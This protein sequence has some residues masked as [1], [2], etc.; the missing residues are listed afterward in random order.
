MIHL[1][2]EI[3]GK[4]LLRNV[5]RF[6]SEHV[7]EF[8][9]LEFLNGAVLPK[10]TRKIGAVHEQYLVRIGMIRTKLIDPEIV[11]IT[12]KKIITESETDVH[13]NGIVQAYGRSN[14]QL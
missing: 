9:P 3:T 13:S 4:T 11:R 12:H 8:L 2:I 1:R 6:A 5:K 14:R 7:C 10:I